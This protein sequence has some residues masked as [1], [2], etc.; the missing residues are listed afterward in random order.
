M[1]IKAEGSWKIPNAIHGKVS[2]SYRRLHQGWVKVLGV[3]KLSWQEEV[4]AYVPAASNVVIVDYFSAVDWNNPHVRKRLVIPPGVEIGSS[5]ATYAFTTSYYAAGAAGS[6]AGELIVDNY[7]TISG[8]GGAPNSGVGGNAVQ[9]Q[10]GGQA[11]QKYV[12]NNYGT[13]RA[14]GGGGGRGGNGGPGV[15]Y[16][17]QASGP[18]YAPYSYHFEGQQNSYQPPWSERNIFWNGTKLSFGYGPHPS[19]LDHAGWRY[20]PGAWRE[21]RGGGWVFY[22]VR[23]ELITPVANHTAGGIAGNAGRGQGYDGAA[24][25]GAAPVAGGTNAGASGKS[26]DGGGWG[27]SG[28]TGNTGASGNNGSGTAGAAGGLAGYYLLGSAYITLNNYG[29][30]QGRLS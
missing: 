13:I 29:T 3:W 6:F 19:Y 23:R 28:A 8:I 5:N 17:S 11:G 25:A 18:H 24:S 22:E 9:A 16:D 27:A 30:V 14:G 26:G 7:G 2:G 12:L 21:N 10:H 1:R 4:V 20:Y 15:W